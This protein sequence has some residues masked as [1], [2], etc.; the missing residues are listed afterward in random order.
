MEKKRKTVRKYLFQKKLYV[1][2]ITLIFII[3]GIAI[4]GNRKQTI[5]IHRILIKEENDNL[6]ETYKELVKSSSILE[7]AIK[8]LAY[9]VNVQE[10]DSMVEVERILNAEMIEIRVRNEN[11]QM[12]EDFSREISNVFIKNINEI[13]K[14]TEIYDVDN[15]V[16]EQRGK[17]SILYALELGVLGFAIGIGF[18][19][20][21]FWLKRNIKNC[22]DIEEITG[23]KSLIALPNVKKNLVSV[24][25]S[26]MASQKNEGFKKLMTNIQFVNLNQQNSKSIL[27]TSSNIQ[28]GKTYIANRLAI[29]FAKV[30]QKVILIDSDMRKGELKTKYH[31]PSDLGLSNYLSNLD[32]NG[33]R[34]N[35]RI[36]RFINDTEIKNLNVI[37]CRK[38]TA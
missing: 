15:N 24:S 37:T 11:Q 36:T 9:S 22:D 25:V 3:A 12:A 20:L 4:S 13:Y 7:E 26:E 32:S 14:G 31:L 19:C 18:F 1:I 27:V 16:I 8:N 33:N 2:L 35:E 10:L 21:L 29:E 34:I 5:A 30:G 38:Y 17:T 23:L 28:E 6:L